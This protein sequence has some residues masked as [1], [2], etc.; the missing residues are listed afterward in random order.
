MMS[1]MIGSIADRI[2]WGYLAAFILLLGSYIL[3][4]YTAQQLLTQANWVKYTNSITN[5]LNSL[6]AAVET[7][8]SSF[9]GYIII[10][11][12]E[13]LEAYYNSATASDSIQKKLKKLVAGSSVQVKRVDS[14][15]Q[16]IKDRFVFMSSGFDIFRRQNGQVSD[17]IKNLVVKGK[18]KMLNIAGLMQ[19]MQF[20]EN[21]LMIKRSERLSSFSDFMK[22]INVS[23][24]ILAIL[25]TIYSIVT[26]TKENKAK[27]Q[28][29]K[30]SAVF[31]EQLEMRVK[32]LAQANKELLELRSMEKFA[33][34][35]RISRTI[36]HEV[37]NPLT[38]INLAAE[39]L[40]S[41][42]PPSAETD[43]LVEMITRNGN[44]INHLISDLLNT[45][46]VTQLDFEKASLNE[47]LDESLQFAKDRLEL[48]G[49]RVIKNYTAECSILGDVEKLKVA[50]LNIIVNAI[51]AMEPGKG[52]L[53]IRTENK[54]DQCSA[55][56]SDNGKGMSNEQLSK[57]FEPYFTTKE[58]G[59]GLGLAHTQNIILS[60]KATISAESDEGKGTSFTVLLNHS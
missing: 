56:I 1:N 35:G 37:R 29:D 24:L 19:R 40:R 58:N 51:E 2:R 11:D 33:V 3:S 39:H 49:I 54:S 42:I 55:I 48:K 38:N 23:S 45:T 13:F 32:E 22:I 26:F 15:D 59:T 6:Q 18:Q 34:T 47:I 31:R 52:V 50:F 43:L 9:R 16:L 44:R 46:K 36:A 7:A 30:N 41:E 25:L 17:S 8:E 14:L 4:F 28:A 21:Q 27:E 57:L 12:R 60:H 53:Q 20:E 10:K 5:S